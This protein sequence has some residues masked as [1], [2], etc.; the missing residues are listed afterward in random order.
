MSGE[1]KMQI[2]KDGSLSLLRGNVLKTQYCP[3]YSVT[4]SDGPSC[5][6]DWCPHFSEPYVF[7][8]RVIRIRIC[9]EKLM[10]CNKKNFRDLRLP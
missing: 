10:Q 5:C 7:D 3:F 1:I 8:D 4:Q 6:G 2:D 9:Y